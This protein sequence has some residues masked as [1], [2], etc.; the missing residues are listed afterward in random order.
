MRL[1]LAV[2]LTMF[3]LYVP[4]SGYAAE[5]TCDSCSDCS[6]K[7]YAASSGDVVKLTTDVFASSA[8]CI[9]ISYVSG[10]TFDC[11]DHI[12]DCSGSCPFGIY[13]INADYNT[14]RN[15][16]VQNFYYGIFADF[17]NH[18][19]IENIIASGNSIAGMQIVGLSKNNTVEDSVFSSNTGPYGYGIK[20]TGNVTNNRLINVTSNSNNRG[21]GIY[22]SSNFNV[23]TDVIV[24][25]NTEFGIN[26]NESRSNVVNDSRIE[27]NPIGIWMGII[28]ESNM[29]YNNYFDN[30]DNA[31]IDSGSNSWNITK[32]PGANI[33][34]NSYIGGNYWSDYSG[35]DLNGDGLGEMSYDLGG[36]NYD[37]LPLTTPSSLTLRIDLV[38]PTPGN[39]SVLGTD[40]VFVNASANDTL[41]SCLLEWNGVNESMTVT[42]SYCYKN[43]TGLSDGDYSFRVWGNDSLGNIGLNETMQ[44]SIDTGSLD[45]DPPG[46]LYSI[47]PKLVVNGS[48]V[49]LMINASDPS[50]IDGVWM[51]I[52]MPDSGTQIF[53]PANREI[54]NFTANL[55]GRYNVTLFANDTLNNEGNVS[56]YFDAQE[57]IPEVN[58][59]IRVENK[60]GGPLWCNVTI[61]QT[62][63]PT[64][65]AS[66]ESGDGVFNDSIPDGTY[67]YLFE[68]FNGGLEV[69]LIGISLSDNTLRT[70]GLDK[71]SPPTGYVQTYAIQSDYLFSNARVR[72][73]YTDPLFQNESHIGVY[74][75]DDWN[76][77]G[78]AC[79]SSWDKEIATINTTLNYA[80]VYVSGLSAFSLKQESYCGDGVCSSDENTTLCPA[81]CTCD[82]GDSRA[83]DETYKGWCGIGYETCTGGSWSGCN[84][85]VTETCDNV[86][87]DCDGVV[88]DVDEGTSAESSQ[89]GCYGDGTPVDEI[90]NGIDDDCDGTIDEGG[91]CCTNGQTKGCGPTMNT[92]ICSTGTSTCTNNLWGSCD[93]AVYAASEVCGNNEDDDCD[94]ET[95]EECGMEWLG[96]A[97]MLAGVLILIV[98]VILFL[99]FRSKGKELTWAEV[100]RKWSPAY[101]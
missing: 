57:S 62:T 82:P 17:S 98:I 6:S 3:F 76:F 65:V 44:I 34:G 96:I 29:V 23:L 47:Q 101:E 81:D 48:V 88:D 7:I 27:N 58:F 66:Y 89:C 77:T 70:I 31:R 67:D 30:A 50:G 37:Y 92:G 39:E 21:I 11:Q 63:T 72:I 42:G 51:V 78:S 24:N 73:Y 25:S 99:H 33:I 35:N 36:G 1:L 100:K 18:S 69:M 84:D 2:F 49:L 55:T 9:N 5:Y 46:I 94:G 16:S 87:N 68:S 52:T 95:D 83:C 41:D 91:D 22:S 4:A 13:L 19:R 10:V 12:V 93:G 14:V 54:V 60:T 97:L 59:T 61:Y 26:I 20:L 90:C 15:C 32:T 8:N 38:S 53:Y 74:V 71:P 28:S 45:T 85:P 56:D 40:W 86:D 64:V 75:C 43:K 79:D 80:D